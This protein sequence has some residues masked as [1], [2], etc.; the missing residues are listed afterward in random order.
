[1]SKIFEDKI[2]PILKYVGFIGASLMSVAYIGIIFV[3]VNGF[4]SNPKAIQD[5]IFAI[6]NAVIGIIIM[7]FL[8]IQGIAFAEDLEENKKILQ[9]YYKTETKDKKIHSI[10]YFWIKSV[11][12]DVI[13]KGV[14]IVI[15]TTGL[16]YIVVVG[17]HDY[18]L[19]L[20]AVV[21]LIMFI[22]FG[23]L[24]LVKAYDFFNNNHIPFILKQLKEAENDCT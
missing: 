6:V 20:L 13:I 16:I 14:S 9:Q 1:M 21:N 4:K 8:K 3:L 18:N 15:A 22:C 23:F 17:S 5:L 19:I 12:L 7:Q 11:I 10:K 24:S 2:K